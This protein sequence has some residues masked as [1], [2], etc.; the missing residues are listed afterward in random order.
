M[1]GRMR[2]KIKYSGFDRKK[3]N[4][5]NRDFFPYADITITWYVMPDALTISKKWFNRTELRF[6]YYYPIKKDYKLCNIGRFFF[7]VT[8]KL[9]NSKKDLAESS[10]ISRIVIKKFNQ[11]EDLIFIKSFIRALMRNKDY[12]FKNYDNYRALLYA[13]NKHSNSIK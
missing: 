12:A 13:L 1:N 4:P 3:K 9:N 8:R 7:Y 5:F 10:R 11:E 2:I 6:N